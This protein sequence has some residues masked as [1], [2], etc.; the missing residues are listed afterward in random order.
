MLDSKRI[1]MKNQTFYTQFALVNCIGLLLVLGMLLIPALAHHFSMG[2][3]S[4]FLLGG[5]VL[6][7]FISG[8]KAL[9]SQNKNDFTRLIIGLIFAK[10]AVCILGVFI[11]NKTF[12]PSDSNYLIPFFTLYLL[13]SY[14]EFKVLSALGYQK[15]N[16][17]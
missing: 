11:Y 8:K 6:A 3:F 16:N 9:A 1:E 15:K 17:Q 12:L 14:F 10:F 13:Y 2:I 4:I 7:S 5:F